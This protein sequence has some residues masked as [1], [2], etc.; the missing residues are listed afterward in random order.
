MAGLLEGAVENAVG[1]QDGARRE[2]LGGAVAKTVSIA[3]FGEGLLWIFFSPNRQAIHDLVADTVVL[4]REGQL[5]GRQLEAPRRLSAYR[6]ATLLLFIVSTAAILG[7]I[8]VGQGQLAVV[9]TAV[10]VVLSLIGMVRRRATISESSPDLARAASPFLQAGEQV[11]VL[12]F[13]ED[14]AGPLGGFA[15][16]FFLGAIGIVIHQFTVRR[17]LV[18]LTNRR[19]ILLSADR[20][21][22]VGGPVSELPR[23]DVVASFPRSGPLT[24][25]FVVQQPNGPTIADLRFRGV[26]A[27]VV[28]DLRAA[29]TG[30]R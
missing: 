29:L 2:A 18:V 7:G 24:G 19:L 1:V 9:G 22:R 6:K 11:D 4:A 14:A 15:A 12:A 17:Y 3:A 16:R 10:F 13:A 20:S 28:P 30:S 26:W 27:A 5:G 8:L 23:S 21:A 25:R